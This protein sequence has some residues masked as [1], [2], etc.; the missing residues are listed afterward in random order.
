MKRI[1]TVCW[2]I[3]LALSSL[4]DA[5][6]AQGQSL[7]DMAT[8]LERL[9][10]YPDLIVVNGRIATMDA[11]LAQVQAMAIRN[12][13]IL[14][15]G[16]NEEIR[17]L[18]GPNTEVLDAK[19]RTVLPGMIDT[20]T[21]PHAWAIQHWLGAEGDATARKYNDPQLKIVLAK[22]NDPIEVLRSLERVVRQRAL[23]LG[24]GKWI[25]VQL[26]GKNTLR[27]S[28]EITWPLVRPER[29]TITREML[30]TFAPDNP[31]L[32]FGSEAIAGS[33]HNTKA[34]ELMEKYLGRELFAYNF[35]STAVVFDILFRGRTEEKMD[36][37]RRELLECLAAQGITTHANNYYST[38][39]IMKIH[40]L[41]S[42]RGEL[43][44][45]WAWWIG[46]GGGSD[47]FQRDPSLAIRYSKA[48]Y[49]DLGD[50]QG[51]GND[52]LWNAGVTPVGAGFDTKLICTTAKPANPANLQGAGTGVSGYDGPRPDC[53]TAQINYDKDRGYSNVRE[54][55]ESG[56]RVGFM[57]SLSDGSFDALFHMLD[58]AVAE[59][60]LTVDQIRALRV[61]TEHTPIIRPDQIAKIARYGIRPSFTPYTVQGDLKGGAFLK[62]YGEQYMTWMMPLK[63]LVS[64]GA[65]PVFGS[66]SHLNKVP[67]EWKDMDVPPQWS[68]NL[69]AFMEF[70]ATREIPDERLTYNKAEALDKVTLLK[71][72]TVWGAE[73]VLNEKNIGSL[74]TGKLADFIVI[75]KDY[76]TIPDNQ[77]H[78]IKVLLTALGGKTVFKAPSF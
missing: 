18:T 62:A 69:W 9:K 16:S 1:A 3:L 45:R 12:S 13:R 77:I 78:T 73:E 57:H 48:F 4:L 51:I 61:T 53:N 46:V 43:P 63:S 36:F 74:E 33:S 23:E 20:H 72:M 17:A 75:D 7:A 60:K 52:F 29:P 27:E 47:E 64:A 55:L 8:K 67:L 19:G 68:G 39:S 40:R 35:A 76:F 65:H 41:L 38:S 26:F 56:L 42:Q 21:H 71:A 11:Q 58:Q 54:A 25:M 50:F 44:V 5:R 2:P 70:F 31:L 32:V 15:L 24:P 34:K 10:A 28:R 37:L 49:G 66:D 14:A 59:G 22:G 30:D 6:M